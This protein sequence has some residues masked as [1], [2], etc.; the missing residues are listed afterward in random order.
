[1]QRDTHTRRGPHFSLR[2]RAGRIRA[3][4]PDETSTHVADW[5]L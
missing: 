4:L 2:Y 5:T 3:I 1:M